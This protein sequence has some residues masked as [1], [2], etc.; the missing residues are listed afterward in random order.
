MSGPSSRVEED[1]GFLAESDEEISFVPRP[2]DDDDV[3]DNLNKIIF[4]DDPP[5]IIQ[6]GKEASQEEEEEEEEE[7][8]KE[9]KKTVYD[10]EVVRIAIDFLQRLQLIPANQRRSMVMPLRPSSLCRFKN[11]YS[12]TIEEMEENGRTYLLD[13]ASNDKKKLKHLKSHFQNGGLVPIEE[14]RRTY[15]AAKKKKKEEN[16]DA[17]EKDKEMRDKKKAERDRKYLEFLNKPKIVLKTTWVE[18]VNEEGEKWMMPKRFRHSI[19]RMT[20]E[21]TISEYTEN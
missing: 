15:A 2:D 20:G 10:M 4:K 13:A 6:S 9:E 14:L 16:E 7:K 18:V 5:V 19:N 21:R 17:K 1:V 11:R 3:D 12:V 8:K